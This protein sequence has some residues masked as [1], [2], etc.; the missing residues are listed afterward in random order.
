M[1]MQKKFFLSLTVLYF[2]TNFSL[3]KNMRKL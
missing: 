3:V 1:K 2:L